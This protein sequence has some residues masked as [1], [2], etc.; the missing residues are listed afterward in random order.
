MTSGA[1]GLLSLSN[2]D[3][4]LTFDLLRQC[5]MCIPI[6]LYGENVEKYLLLFQGSG[7]FSIEITIP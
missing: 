7:V 6:H 4:R 1:Q 3:P 5:Q 2:D